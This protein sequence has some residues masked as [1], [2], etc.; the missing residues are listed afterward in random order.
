VSD[1]IDAR[2]ALWLRELNG[3]DEQQVDGEHTAA[4]LRLIERVVENARTLNASARDRLL[5]GLYRLTFGDRVETTVKCGACGSPYD[6]GFSLEQLMASVSRT[7]VPGLVA[8]PDGSYSLAGG[9]RFRLPAAADELA[10]SSLRLD[11]AEAGLRARCTLEPGDAEAID[12][13]MQ[14]IAPILSLRIAAGCP[15]CGAA[16]QFEFDVQ[17]FLLSRIRKERPGRQREVH[18]LASAYGWGLTEILNLP[19]SERRA[20]C[21]LVEN[22][23]EGQRRLR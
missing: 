17:R 21:E 8:H 14:S 18:R 2:A 15:E 13:A 12:D 11:Q 19:R 20:F 23:R 22:E 5:A 1:A 4:A 16:Q 7:A 3:S 10:V 6:L 9:G